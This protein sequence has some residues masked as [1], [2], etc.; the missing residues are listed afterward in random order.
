MIGGVRGPFAVIDGEVYGIVTMKDV[1]AFIFGEISGKMAG[2]EL[3]KEDDEN[4]YVVP[5]D[6]RLADF[7]NLTNFD[8]EDP[9]M[10]TIGGAAFRWFDRLPEPGEHVTHEGYR[11]VVKER[12]GLRISQVLV[13]KIT[14]SGEAD[15][16]EH[17]GDLA[18]STAADGEGAQTGESHSADEP[19]GAGAEAASAA[20][21]SE[22]TAKDNTKRKKN[23]VSGDAQQA[24][25]E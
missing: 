19:P 16:E 24:G 8:I 11:F 22:A 13:Q 17:L 2:Q 3:Y 7:N 21:E 14:S 18:Q 25:E 23:K 5:G 20:P 4:S 10:A 15:E 1:L 12:K 9:V 6:M